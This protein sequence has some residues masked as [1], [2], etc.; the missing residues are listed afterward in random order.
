MIW[1]KLAGA[2]LVAAAV[3][4]AAGAYAESGDLVQVRG[5]VR[6]V[7][8]R[9]R[10]EGAK[11][12]LPSLGLST[13]TDAGGH[14]EM[15]ALVSCGG[16]AARF[17]RLL[18]N[19][20]RH[21]KRRTWID[22]C[23]QADALGSV[24]IIP[25]GRAFDMRFFSQAFRGNGSRGTMRWVDA[26]RFEIVNRVVQFT[27]SLQCDVLQER[28]PDAWMSL[29]ETVAE[30]DV[31]PLSDGYLTPPDVRRA[32][33]TA[34]GLLENCYASFLEPGVVRYLLKRG[35]SSSQSS[36][37]GEM[38]DGELLSGVIFI[39]EAHAGSRS[40]QSHELAHA[41]GWG[42]PDG[43]DHM[44][45]PSVMGYAEG[46]TSADLEHAKVLYSRF[47]GNRKPDRDPRPATTESAA[48]ARRRAVVIEGRCRAP[49]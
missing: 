5:T 33:P 12:R 13:R 44:I 48:I 21:W 8:S 36:F 40:I 10:L 45:L 49:E 31:L 14:F 1:K 6:D 4:I 46:P 11:V 30:E 28:P 27:G 29:V 7:L 16:Q 35:G 3:G 23:D 43:Q 32:G 26:P 39:A 15:E 19:K 9:D 42:H 2:S 20:G 18:L 38:I 37:T 22:V 47:P 24:S 41:L 25:R 34:S 17:E